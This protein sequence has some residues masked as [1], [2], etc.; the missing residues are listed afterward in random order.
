MENYNDIKLLMRVSDMCEE[1]TNKKNWYRKIFNNEIIL[2]WKNEIP[3]KSYDIFVYVVNLLRATAQGSLYKKDCK[4]GD[5]G[6]CKKCLQECILDDPSDF[7]LDDNID[8]T[9]FEQ[10]GWEIPFISDP[11]LDTDFFECEHIKCD[12]LPPDKDLSSYVVYNNNG[13]ISKNL[14]DKCRRVINNIYVNEPVDY[15]PGSND[16]V[17][18]IIHPSIFCY[19]KGIS[20]HSDGTKMLESDESLRYQ[21]LPSEFIISSDKKIKNLS[22]IN[23]LDDSKYPE[24]I[25]LVEEV[26]EQFLPSLEKVLKRDLK[27]QQLQI[28]VKAGSTILNNNNPNFDG[29][30]WHVEGMPYEHIIATCI[31]YVQVEHITPSYLEFRKPVIFNEINL[32]YPQCDETFTK[33]HYGIEPHCDGKMNR[34]LGL[35][36]CDQ[37]SSV[38]FP[39]TLQ[40]HVKNFEL[41]NNHN[42]GIRTILAFFVIDPDHRIIS[43]AD[44]PKQQNIFT[45]ADAKYYRERLMLHRKYFVDELNDKVFEREYSLCEH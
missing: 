17:V 21:W 25:P 4:W 12:C 40:H 28:I 38:V 19:V 9:F 43:T 6:E 16:Q 20:K 29:G 1:I 30:S 33:H 8:E 34:Y 5:Y 26:F 37:G 27:N 41:I 13:L 18:D 44:I 7:G 45:K 42:E 32:D 15:H 10:P 22:Y 11:N 3:E 23:N 14:N 39:N 2:K 24:F 36:K 31:Q 35:I